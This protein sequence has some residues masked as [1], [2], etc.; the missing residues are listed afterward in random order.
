MFVIEISIT[1]VKSQREWPAV[2]A[3]VFRGFPVCSC[4]CDT[5]GVKSGRGR[6]LYKR[7]CRSKRDT[8]VD[9]W[10]NG[11][12]GAIAGKDIHGRKKF[13]MFLSLSLCIPIRQIR[14]MGHLSPTKCTFRSAEIFVTDWCSFSGYG[15]LSVRF[16]G[17]NQANLYTIENF[18]TEISSLWLAYWVRCGAWE[19]IVFFCGCALWCHSVFYPFSSNLAYCIH[20]HQNVLWNCS[21]SR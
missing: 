20:A 5:V 10:Q 11:T 12:E 13:G 6:E 14:R 1:K 19:K 21:A 2:S 15:K 18:S 9:K 17:L 4:E 7:H 8:Y 3:Q 16:N